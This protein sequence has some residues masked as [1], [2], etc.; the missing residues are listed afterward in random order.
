MQEQL[1]LLSAL[2]DDEIEA[3]ERPRIVEALIADTRLTAAWRSYN[4]IGEALR[5][6]SGRAAIATPPLPTAL[7]KPAARTAPGMGFRPVAGLALAAAA[8]IVAIIMARPDVTI[9]RGSVADR[10]A[11]DPAMAA[12]SPSPT[13][14]ASS[15]RSASSTSAGTLSANGAKPPLENITV[16]TVR[17]ED[18]APMRPDS[19]LNSYLVNFNEHRVNVGVQSV[20]PYVR[21][22]GYAPAQ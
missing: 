1:E 7:S 18:D 13:L 15:N 8:G 4:L 16:T 6:M 3:H 19:R 5:E 20:H 21:I 10:K 2:V 22:V 14:V 9:E 11:P 17:Y 12:P